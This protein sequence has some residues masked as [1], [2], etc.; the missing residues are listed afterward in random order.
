MLT[1]ILTTYPPS[2]LAWIALSLFLL[3]MSKGGFPV[4]SIAMPILV[5]MWPTQTGAARAAVGFLL[6]MLCLMDVVATTLYRKHIQWSR[7]WRMIPGSIL[8]VG[9]AAA[10][11]ISDQHALIQVTD[12]ALRVAIGILGLIFVAWHVANKQIR[13]TLTKTHTPGWAACSCY[14]TTAG[15]TSSLAHAAAPIM[16]MVLL[17]QKL[18][19]L[20]F[21]A[22]MTAYFLLLNL[23]KMVP[24]T[25]MGRI[26]IPNLLLGLLLLPILPA[27]VLSGFLLVRVTQEKHYAT[28]IYAALA[29]ASFFL[30]LNGIGK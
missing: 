7:I 23:I 30:I 12:G 3:G 10:L 17:P 11:F 28:L 25:L 6:P 5:L 18:P 29:V 13:R 26:Q 8:G 15:I 22:T 20:Q 16:Q 9:I 4:G 2:G 21:A 19:K 14:G 24:F 1:D 27:G